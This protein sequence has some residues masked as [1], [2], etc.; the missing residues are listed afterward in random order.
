LQT[1]EKGAVLGFVQS[2]FGTTKW[3]VHGRLAFG[4][5]EI[6]GEYRDVGIIFDS[7]KYW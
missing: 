4:E 5:A 3:Q 1:V 7:L 6:D 2:V